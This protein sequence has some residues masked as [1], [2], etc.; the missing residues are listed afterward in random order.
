MDTF[1]QNVSHSHGQRPAAVV[2]RLTQ[3]AVVGQ[4]GSGQEL[5]TTD[6]KEPRL[7]RQSLNFTH[8]PKSKECFDAPHGTCR[9]TCPPWPS[10][11]GWGPPGGRRALCVSWAEAPPRPGPGTSRRWS[12][13]GSASRPAATGQFSRLEYKNKIK[14]DD[15]F[16]RWVKVK[17]KQMLPHLPQ[18]KKSWHCI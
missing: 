12:W 9:P 11:R 13:P 5:Y 4:P 18:Q 14:V 1:R 16:T 17:S 15:R 10:C 2:H 6:D 7:R 8:I 3:E